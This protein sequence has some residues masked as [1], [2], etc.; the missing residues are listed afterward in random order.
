MSKYSNISR[1]LAW[2]VIPYKHLQ[3]AYQYHLGGHHAQPPSQKFPGAQLPTCRRSHCDP[4][5]GSP[6]DSPGRC[7]EKEGRK[8]EKSH[9]KATALGWNLSTSRTS[10][11]SLVQL[12]SASWYPSGTHLVP[13]SWG[14]GSS[15]SYQYTIQIQSGL[16]IR[17]QRVG[18]D[19]T[20]KLQRAQRIQIHPRKNLHKVKEN[21]RNLSTW[22]MYL[23]YLEIFSADTHW[24]HEIQYILKSERV[25]TSQGHC[26]TSESPNL[27]ESPQGASRQVAGLELLR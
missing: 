10:L 13:L 11:A 8:I 25:R 7:A 19:G 20:L 21:E 15:S 27:I 2:L 22:N 24:P 17:G 4:G 14:L 3:T 5:S 12:I 1:I 16:R 26:S 18:S 6:D 23:K 9:A